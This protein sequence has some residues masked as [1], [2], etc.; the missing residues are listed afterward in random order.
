MQSSIVS[1]LDDLAQW[2]AEVDR[3]LSSLA[4]F[5]ADHDLADETQTASIAALRSRLA[6]DRMVL[7]FVAEFSRGK[8]EL[9]NAIFF[10]DAGRRVMPATPGRTTMCP[11]E[12][13][14]SGTSPPRLSLLPIE[15]RVRGLSLAELRKRD[16]PW[17]HIP[18]DVADP[19]SLARSLLAVT[20]T[21]RVNIETATALGLWSDDHPE[22]NP[23]RGADGL[24]EV[25]AWRH[26]LIDYPHPL[27]KR[28]LV[29]IDTPGLNAIGAEPELT[30]GLLPSAHA[31]VFVLAADTG[32]TKSDLAIWRDH[33][34]HG[35]LD[36][37]VVL[38]KIDALY[39]PLASDDDV[40]RQI[41]AQR[42]SVAQ[43]L[44]LPVERVF[45]LSAR[46][47][48]AARVSGSA[49]MLERSN[50]GAL[51]E[52]LSSGLLPRQQE[53]LQA[54]TL[55]VVQ[56][57]REVAAR[58]IGEKRRHQT[59]QML[60][61]KGLRGKS[62][63][64]VRLMLQ[65]VDAESADFERCV[66]R[67]QAVRSV[68]QRLLKS[69]LARIS[70]QVLRS[71]VSAMQSAL[72]ARAFNL[73]GKAA[74]RTLCERLGAALEDAQK[75]ADEMREMLDGSFMQL[76]AEYGFAFARQAAPELQRFVRE[77]DLIDHNY[78]QYLGLL[79][80]WRMASPGF[81]EQFRRMLL[82]KLRVVFESASS[83]LELWSR[84]ASHQVEQ[85][86]GDRRRSFKQRRDALQRIQSAAGE[87]EQRIAEV[88]SQDA[89]L[90]ELQRH[91]DARVGDVLVRARRALPA[92]AH[93]EPAPADSAA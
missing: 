47:G 64:K 2:R 30:L 53:M 17:Q 1:R 67:L 8:S 61:L 49:G 81:M 9:I 11:V 27:L 71:E 50:L 29:V 85:Q 66:A 48:L 39:D 87:L 25:P 18:L 62:G 79:Q 26:A 58:R 19:D 43:T 31:I 42:R 57:V 82:S 44:S 23:P 59:E 73:G 15:T 33:I 74:F 4:R 89:Q 60:E 24:V 20:R 88:E 56:R 65:R 38:N 45:A 34:G 80:A 28:G 3:S 93:A 90:A 41:L 40:R 83:E 75:Q 12:L 72:E 76:N 68:Q 55:A 21:Q 10:A 46:E 22:D 32:V 77:L 84:T 86:L 91:L 52:A 63:S 69:A 78:S 70:T 5:L 13:H 36:R 14:H 54:G 16:E 6:S 92:A 7:A 37:Y 51:E 35:E